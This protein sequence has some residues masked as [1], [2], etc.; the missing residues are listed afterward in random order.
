MELRI[1]MIKDL[2][3]DLEILNSQK[4]KLANID[5]KELAKTIV[6]TNIEA[7]V[8]IARQLRLRN[9]AGIIII[10]FIDMKKDSDRKLVLKTLENELKND[11]M[12]TEII[13]FSSIN[14]VQLTRQRQ[15]NELSY[16]Y[17][18]P[19]FCC[20]GTGFI[21]SK[22]SIILE[23]LKE[24]KNIANDRDIRK[25]ELVSQKELIKEIKKDFLEYIE[26]ILEKQ[27]KKIEFLEDNFITSN[28]EI[29]LYK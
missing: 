9:L 14:L 3:K 26:K 18:E 8:E 27:N 10:D 28:Y 19:C 23:I 25:I 11:R 5:D 29:N 4:E 16:Y 24:L 6:E 20:E 7:A 17:Q 13:N 21:K 1:S 2:E 22:E 12:K 15:G